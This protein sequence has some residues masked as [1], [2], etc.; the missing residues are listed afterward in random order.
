[1]HN[2]PLTPR[3]RGPFLQVYSR[4]VQVGLMAPAQKRAYT[5]A[6]ELLVPAALQVE[7]PSRWQAFRFS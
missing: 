1:M 4:A 2:R 7:G 5:A 3:E 6:S